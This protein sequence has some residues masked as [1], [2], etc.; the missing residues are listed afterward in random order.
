MISLNNFLSCLK[1]ME[2]TKIVQLYLSLRSSMKQDNMF[3][4]IENKKLTHTKESKQ[5]LNVINYF[6][7]LIENFD[8]S[9]DEKQYTQR[10]HQ[11]NFIRDRNTFIR[12]QLQII[13]LEIEQY[14]TAYTDIMNYLS[15]KYKENKMFMTEESQYCNKSFTII[16]N[17]YHKIQ[18]LKEK[19]RL[20]ME[21]IL[22]IP[23]MKIFLEK[24]N[25][26][27]INHIYNLKLMIFE[28]N[29]GFKIINLAHNVYIDHLLK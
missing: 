10:Y 14:E 29:E 16:L 26:N 23:F 4:I 15:D 21:N 8:Y 17:Y 5:Y 2:D 11:N 1:N 24:S 20:Y 12:T 19:R 3:S 25:K 22:S 28:I 27:N 7:Y 9:D 6:K 13:D 18:Q